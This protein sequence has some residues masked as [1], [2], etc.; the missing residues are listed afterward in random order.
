MAGSSVATVPLNWVRSNIASSNK[1]LMTDHQPDVATLS[2]LQKPE[3]GTD[4][5]FCT[6]STLLVAYD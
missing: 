3:L 4:C 2:R 1:G 6:V 5:D